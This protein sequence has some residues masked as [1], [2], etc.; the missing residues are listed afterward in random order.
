MSSEIKESGKMNAQTTESTKRDLRILGIDEAGRGPVLG[1]LFM[2][3]CLFLKSKMDLL[4]N[5]E[6]N[7]SKKL[8]PKK[9][10]EL[11]K[12]IKEQAEVTL[13]ERISVAEIDH[14][15]LNKKK[16]LN[17]LEIEKM[18]SIIVK[19]RPDVVY[20]DAIGSKPDKFK[21]T[22]IKRLKGENI[23]N[24][25]KIIAENRADS[26]FKIVGAASILAKVE[27]DEA[28]NRTREKYS[29]YG[30]IGSGYTSDWKTQ[31]FLKKF[32]E[33]NREFPEIARKSWK[34]CANLIKE[35]NLKLDNAENRDMLQ[36][37]IS[38]YF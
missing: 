27:R 19:T 7:D 28:L 24:I 31:N 12:F 32:Y 36:K 14:N 1:D 34:T 16:S 33:K 10:K 2:G 11:Y 4:T 37:D 30:E 25:P 5:S 15:L 23:E 3:G 21:R 13:T 22:L 17:E 26:K 29:L 6:V 18:I 38:D 9:R 20:I 35:Y 8:S